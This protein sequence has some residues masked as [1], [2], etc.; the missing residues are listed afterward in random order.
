LHLLCVPLNGYLFHAYKKT[1]TMN[2][3]KETRFITL[4]I[5]GVSNITFDYF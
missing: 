3:I 4:L 2:K 5:E 1:S